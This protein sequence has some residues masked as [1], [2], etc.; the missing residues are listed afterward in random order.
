[1][2]SSNWQAQVPSARIFYWDQ[3][4]AVLPDGS[5]FDLFWTFDR[6]AVAYLNIHAR[7]SPDGRTFSDMY[8]T[9]VPGQPAA[10]VALGDGTLCMVYVDRTAA[11]AIK[12]RLSVDG[13][14]NWFTEGQCIIH[15]S[16]SSQT[17]AKQDMQDAWEEMGRFS[18]GL[19]ATAPLPA[20][21]VLVVYYAG[22][23][24]D[25]TAIHWSRLKLC[26]PAAAG[27]SASES[28]DGKRAST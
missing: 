6:S 18:L 26:V 27:A 10:P 9:G 11:P 17:L 3:R 4:P 22:D 15:A 23:Q 28:P 19:P 24:T 1:L 20:N 12:A 21:E 2:F 16:A 5:V 14:R 13:G 7:R 25:R 8:D